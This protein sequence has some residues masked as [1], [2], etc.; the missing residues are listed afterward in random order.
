MNIPVVSVII[1]TYNRL[2]MLERAVQSV[3]AQ[4]FSSF[5]IIVANDAGE[6]VEPL[7][8]RLD[9]GRKCIKFVNSEQKSGVSAM[10]NLALNLA[11]G[12]YIAYLDDDDYYY[13]EHI[14]LLHSYL[15]EN[16]E[17]VVYSNS[18]L[19][20]QE[21][22]NDIWVTVKKELQFDNEF[23]FDQLLVGN[24][25]PILNIMHARECLEKSGVFDETL[26]T[27]EDWD[28]WIRMSSCYAFHH[29]DKI[30]AE[31]TYRPA[32]ES[33]K[34]RRVYRDNF[35][36]TRELIYKKYAS[37]VAYK[38]E[39]RAS[40]QKNIEQQQA[41]RKIAAQIIPF[42]QGIKEKL[43][44]KDIQGAW[45]YYNQ[46]RPANDASGTVNAELVRIDELMRS[47][48]RS[49]PQPKFYVCS[50][51]CETK[52]YCDGLFLESLSNLTYQNKIIKIIDNTQGLDYLA[53]LN[54]IKDYFENL[55]SCEIKH[56]D[57][58]LEPRGSLFNRAVA[59]SLLFL[60]KDFLKSDCDYFV[61]IESDVIVPPNLL[62][63]FCE[64][65]GNADLIGGL[66]Y[67]LSYHT[68][69]DW[70]GDDFVY[71]NGEL[72]GCACFSRKILGKIEFR[73]GENSAA[74]PDAYFSQDAMANG[75]KIG[76]Q[77]KIKCQH[78][79]DGTGFRGHKGYLPPKAT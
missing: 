35:A 64:A 43:R 76:R 78:L 48:P 44:A 25:I 6:S 62:E 52:S 37:L 75:F 79:D 58:S 22:Q 45:E 50:Y 12:K 7:L 1:P 77:R 33:E 65:L 57:I 55:K 47:L 36:D 53:R 13:P 8:C 19:A 18:L 74:F 32:S 42:I 73:Q 26:N 4:T 59:E 51:T 34:N 24:Y 20:T 41:S 54:A 63:L 68:K 2:D 69:E 39:I 29:I 72:T 30:T 14:E 3:L 11:Q 38:P 9:A 5:E 71:S 60:Q 70:E 61:T 31:Y 27:H 66:Y 15:E 17:K 10:R 28:L 56:I 23:D 40:Q 21:K 67:N 16:N 46:H 49:Q